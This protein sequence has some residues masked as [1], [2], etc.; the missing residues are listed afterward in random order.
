V[1]DGGIY[2]LLFWIGQVLVGGLIP[3]SLIF[4]RALKNNHWSLLLASTLVLIGGFA[5]LYVIVV[6]GQAYPLELFPNATVESSF[7]DGEIASYTPSVWE[8]MLGIG[9]VGLSV[10]LVFVGMKVLRFLP[11]SLVDS[12]VQTH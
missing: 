7:F 3:L 5:Q 8:W 2:T 9:G 6:G 1:L 12:E 11:R 10:A 4:C